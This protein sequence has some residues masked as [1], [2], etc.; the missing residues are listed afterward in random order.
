[1]KECA[2]AIRKGALRGYE[3]IWKRQKKGEQVREIKWLKIE[4][5]VCNEILENPRYRGRERACESDGGR[6]RMVEEGRRRKNAEARENEVEN[7]EYVSDLTR[8]RQDGPK[9][10]VKEREKDIDWEE[11]KLWKNTKERECERETKCNRD[12]V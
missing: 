11:R 6:H 8:L 9:G 5:R 10:E 4:G 1:M 2:N 3:Q 12:S 7:G